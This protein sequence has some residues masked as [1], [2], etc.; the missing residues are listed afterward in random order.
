MDK[1]INEI[2]DTQNKK[3]CGFDKWTKKCITSRQT[4]INMKLYV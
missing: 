2:T 1:Q 4:E 3:T